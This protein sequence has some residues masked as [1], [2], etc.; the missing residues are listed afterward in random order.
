MKKIFIS[1]MI[2]IMFATMS[3]PVFA[4]SKIADKITID[5]N[6]ELKP[7]VA[8]SKLIPR[9]VSQLQELSIY[10]IDRPGDMSIPYGY[11]T[12]YDFNSCHI[13][14][15][16]CASC[17]LVLIGTFY[18]EP[19]EDLIMPFETEGGYFSVCVRPT[20]QGFIVYGYGEGEAEGITVEGPILDGNSN[21]TISTE[22]IYLGIDQE[23]WIDFAIVT[24]EVY[25][26]NDFNIWGIY[27]NPF[28]HLPG[29]DGGEFYLNFERSKA[30]YYSFGN[31][32]YTHLQCLE[33]NKE[34]WLKGTFLYDASNHLMY[35]EDTDVYVKFDFRTDCF[36]IFAKGVSRANGNYIVDDPYYW[37]GENGICL[38]SDYSLPM[39]SLFS[40]NNVPLVIY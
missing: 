10:E 22:R 38:E 4:F 23:E 8:S 7:V 31:T 34:I 27:Q 36:R 37:L 29:Q 14:L 12:C 30:T 19:S 33:S 16:E 6:F 2:M 20:A 32:I 21:F 15:V 18:Y 28:G 17:S 39:I 25:E 11:L 3:M 9:D 24:P 26:H 13:T 5:P 1:L 40:L 35:S